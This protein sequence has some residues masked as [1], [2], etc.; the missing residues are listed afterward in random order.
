MKCN[1]GDIAKPIK[2]TDNQ[3]FHHVHPKH[4]IQGNWPIPSARFIL[5][6]PLQWALQ[7][8]VLMRSQVTGS[9]KPRKEMDPNVSFS[10][11]I[12]FDTDRGGDCA[13]KPKQTPLKKS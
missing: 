3:Y 13:H 8:L 1:P 9:K 11:S 6:R 7:L 5:R 4:Q 10:E 12:S 2:S